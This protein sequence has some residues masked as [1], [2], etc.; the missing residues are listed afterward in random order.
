MMNI[1]CIKVYKVID[2]CHVDRSIKTKIQ[3]KTENLRCKQRN[4]FNKVKKRWVSF[5]L[6]RR[7]RK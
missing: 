5:I 3:R 6:L 1:I 7:D 2:I 4:G